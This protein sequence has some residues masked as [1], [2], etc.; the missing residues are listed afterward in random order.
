MKIKYDR[1]VDAAYLTLANTQIADTEEIQDNII[2][3][4]DEADQVVGI[5]LLSVKRNIANLLEL[6]KLFALFHVNRASFEF[7]AFFDFLVETADLNLIDNTKIRQKIAR[8]KVSQQQSSKIKR[9][10]LENL[11]FIAK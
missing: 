9:S 1:Q 8:A 3:D 11:E 6:P 7:P 5:E 10:S 2:F 4:Y